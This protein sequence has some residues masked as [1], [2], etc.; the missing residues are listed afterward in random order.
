[1]HIFKEDNSH[2]P[3]L[4]SLSDHS[5]WFKVSQVQ[6]SPNLLAKMSDSSYCDTAC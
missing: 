2:Y 3:G 5:L 1:M 4:P 6:G